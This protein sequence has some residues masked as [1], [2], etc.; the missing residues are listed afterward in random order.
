MEKISLLLVDDHA[1]IRSGLRM[2]LDAQDDMAIVGEADSGR[3]AI[4][5]S[6]NSS[7]PSRSPRR[8]ALLAM[9]KEKGVMKKRSSTKRKMVIPAPS[10]AAV[11][12]AFARP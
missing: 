5:L 12:G 1:V 2:L 4:D 10:T 6:T 7:A 9:R 8:K 3:A 11:V